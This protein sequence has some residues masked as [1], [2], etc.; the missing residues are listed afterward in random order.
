[1][2]TTTLMNVVLRLNTHGT[3]SR[4]ILV[5][6]Y[7][8]ST[9]LGWLDLAKIP[10]IRGSLEKPFRRPETPKNR[11]KVANKTFRELR[12]LLNAH[13]SHSHVCDSAFNVGSSILM[14][15]TT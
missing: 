6:V 9:I 8:L 4:L 10:A 14:R 1:M 12:Q 15:L 13:V 2:T 5:A 11:G 3:L 7:Y